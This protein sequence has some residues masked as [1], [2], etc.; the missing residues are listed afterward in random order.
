MSQQRRCS[1]VHVRAAVLRC[2]ASRFHHEVCAPPED[3]SPYGLQQAAWVEVVLRLLWEYVETQDS[4]KNHTAEVMDDI[5]SGGAAGYLVGLEATVM[6][7]IM[8]GAE[9]TP[10]G[11]VV[12][13]DRQEV[14]QHLQS[15]ANPV[16]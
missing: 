14:P 7:A 12:A 11:V 16:R 4:L 8:E 10:V 2:R 15:S 13:L 5:M 6:D 9:A 3:V 1:A